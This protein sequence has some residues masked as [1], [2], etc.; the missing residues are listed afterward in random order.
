MRVDFPLTSSL[1]VRFFVGSCAVLAPDCSRQL[2]PR[3]PPTSAPDFRTLHISLLI[4]IWILRTVNVK[5]YILGRDARRL[6]R[7]IGTRFGGTD[8]KVN[9]TVRQHIL[10]YRDNS[11][12][13]LR[14]HGGNHEDYHC[15]LR[16]NTV[17]SG[18]SRRFGEQCGQ[19]GRRPSLPH[20]SA[21]Y[22]LGL[23][24]GLKT[25]AICSSSTSACLQ[26]PRRSFVSVCDLSV[27]TPQDDA[28]F[29]KLL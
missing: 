13:I 12:W 2:K 20:D 1:L 27:Q 14:T 19:Q 24:F 9:Q 8:C 29:H 28:G 7:N 18:R 23:I 15:F 22:L 3:F 16:C 11:R 25:E 10:E 17:S 6:L 26:T 4:R 5:H 21:G